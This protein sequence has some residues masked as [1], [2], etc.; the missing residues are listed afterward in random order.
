MDNFHLKT[1][2]NTVK[3][4]YMPLVVGI[5]FIIAGIYTFASPVSSYLALSI[6]FSLSFLFSGLF[7]VAFSISN[8]NEMENW[9]WMLIFGL[10]TFLFGL[11]MTIH[12][13]ISMATLPLYVGFVLLFRS[14]GAISFAIDI[15]SYG[16]PY[17]GV[18]LT[19]GIAGIIFSTIMLFNKS[20]AGA[21]IITLTG[22]TFLIAGFFGIALSLLLRNIKKISKKVSQNLRDKFDDIRKEIREELFD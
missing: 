2:T 1:L 3:N 7:E 14:I 9:G 17:W 21:S 15:K 6:F 22:I 12:P 8:R 18:L 20:F 4:W 19:L 5:I 11:I 16:V 13:E 10:L